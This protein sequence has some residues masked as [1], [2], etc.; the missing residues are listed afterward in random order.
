MITNRFTRGILI[1]LALLLAFA[2]F[3]TAYAVGKPIRSRAPFGP[4]FTI[5]DKPCQTF[6]VRWEALSDNSYLT[7]FTEKTATRYTVTGVLKS[8]L[9]NETT[10]KS[11][12]LNTSCRLVERDYEDGSWTFACDGP[13]VW[14][15]WPGLPALAYTRG[16]VSFTYDAD[17]NLVKAVR[18]GLVQDLC[19]ALA[20]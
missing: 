1:G 20:P 18:T 9:T 6:D 2:P 19:A 5:A 12:E 4:P 13:S 10:G 14:A 17:G 8:R 11:I 15:N 7:I 16:N 3:A